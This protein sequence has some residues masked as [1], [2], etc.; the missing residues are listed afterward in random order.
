M[1]TISEKVNLIDSGEEYLEP[2]E[3]VKI[4]YKDF[5]ENWIKY[6][7]SLSNF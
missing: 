3:S 1:Y 4:E 5:L 7:K 2:G 6:V